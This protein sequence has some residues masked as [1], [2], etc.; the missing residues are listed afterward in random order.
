MR[1]A[2]GQSGGTQQKENEVSRQEEQE[3]MGA[4]VLH[5]GEE[6]DAHH[7]LT[8]GETGREGALCFAAKARPSTM[9]RMLN[10]PIR[11]M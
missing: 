3:L 10:R 9:R 6:Q 4:G 2:L 8:P 7:Q 5:P 11:P 1:D